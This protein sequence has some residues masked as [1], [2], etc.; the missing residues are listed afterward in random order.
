MSFVPVRCRCI[1]AV[2]V[3]LSA[4]ARGTRLSTGLA[5]AYEEFRRV[6]GRT[7]T[8]SSDDVSYLV[9]LAFFEKRL[10]QVRAHNAKP[11]RLWTAG[12]NQ[13][14][15]YTETEYR[16]LLGHRP[17]RWWR[18]STAA[19]QGSSAGPSS[20]MQVRETRERA[21]TVDWRTT[22][23][24]TMSVHNQGACGSCWA[25]AAAGAIEAALQRLDGTQ[26]AV[27]F[28][29]I[30]DCTPN[31]DECGGRGGCF[32]GTSE[33][34]FG[35]L[36]SHGVVFSDHYQGYLSGGDGVCKEPAPSSQVVHADDFV[37]LPP[38]KLLPLL[39]AVE[40]KGPLAVSIDAS[41]LGAYDHGI[42][43]GCGVDATVNHAVLLIGYGISEGT[44]YYLIRNSWG[45]AWGEKGYFRLLR[46]DSDLGATGHCGTDYAPLDGVGCKRGRNK[47]NDSDPVCGMCGILF[48]SSYPVG[49]GVKQVPVLS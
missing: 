4:T 26:R 7:G 9:R 20:F 31:P 8:Q 32:G 34:A 5:E 19:A 29:H 38:N 45:P 41:T 17:T 10:A 11:G 49:V 37:R 14:A 24:T 48:D 23:N 35:F 36:K 13:F 44:K 2:L 46:H 39:D 22:L 42:F 25:V 27:S 6:H 1:F 30:V 28:E 40:T 12:I 43:D 15:D 33:L 16:G 21:L 18:H 3:S 47:A